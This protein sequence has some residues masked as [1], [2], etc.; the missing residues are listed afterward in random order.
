MKNGISV[1]ASR[2]AIVEAR[3][4]IKDIL[5]ATA[6]QE[7]KRKALGVLST[8]C[9][10]AN[11]TIRDCTFTGSGNTSAYSLGEVK[12]DTVYTG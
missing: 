3:E 7:T 2:D 12:D 1:G 6:D 4:A 11:T 9:R 8:L 10:V 5:K